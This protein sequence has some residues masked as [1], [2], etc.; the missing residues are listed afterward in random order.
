MLWGVPRTAPGPRPPAD[1]VV[2]LAKA[3][4][5]QGPISVLCRYARQ[6]VSK[7]RRVAPASAALLSPSLLLPCLCPPCSALLPLLSLLCL[8]AS[9]CSPSASPSP[10]LS[11]PAAPA[12][13]PAASLR[14]PGP[15]RSAETAIEKTAVGDGRSNGREEAG[16]E[17]GGDVCHT[18]KRRQR[19]ASGRQL[20]RR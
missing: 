4:P 20:A 8:P 2:H 5:R 17:A 7:H 10:V 16:Q 18:H 3:G 19:R 14:P 11:S 13:R 6:E 12:A 1:L 9:L 15:A